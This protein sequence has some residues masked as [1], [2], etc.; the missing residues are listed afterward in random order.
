MSRV[1]LRKHQREL[2]DEIV[3]LLEVP[4][5]GVVPSAGL[6]ATLV[7][8][9][10]TGKTLVGV[11]AA[12]RLVPR[13]RVLVMVPT[14]AL[15][16]QTVEKWREAGDVRE[17]IA[18]CSM[19]GEEVLEE[20]G[21]RCT[22]SAPQLALWGG[23]G[24]VVVFATYA[25]LNLRRDGGGQVV[26]GPL[27]RAM[28]GVYGQ[29]LAPFDLVIVD[30][31]HRT[32]GAWGKAWAAV[33]DNE[34]IPADRRL[35]MTATPRLWALPEQMVAAGLGGGG[36]DV[37]GGDEGLGE[38]GV[39]AAESAA[40]G[41]VEAGEGAEGGCGA[42]RV[43]ASMDDEEL[44]G[45]QVT[46]G[47]LEAVETG[48]LASFEIDVLEI[49]DP[50]PVAE[51]ASLEEARWRRLSALQAALLTHMDATGARSWITFHH[52]TREAMRFARGMPGAAAELY[53]V[54]AARYPAPEWV[55]SEWLCGEHG[56]EWRRAVLGQFAD[57]RDAR[58][59]EQAALFLASCKV[60]GEGVDIV[61]ERGVDGVCFADTRGG[62]VD[63]VQ[64]VG[65]G[66]RQQP[67]EGK[68]A[69][70]VVPVFLQPGESPGDMISSSSYRP[71]V[72][73]L[74]GLRA[75]DERVIEQLVLR[76][77]HT[78][79]GEA[80]DVL[81]EDPQY[82]RE[83]GGERGS[84]EAAGDGGADSGEGGETGVEGAAGAAGEGKGGVGALRFSTPR[85]LAT[86]ARFVRT[87]VLQPD[88]EVWLRGY[89]LLAQWADRWGHARVPAQERVPVGG[90]EEYALGAWVVEQR[91]A[92]REGWLKPWRFERLDAL[93][94]VW[95]VRDAR[96]EEKL[97]VFRRYFEVHA[98]LAAPL[99][100]V[101]ENHPVGQDLANLRK[102]GGLGKKP[103]RAAERRAALEAIDPDWN[104]EWPVAWQRRWAKVRL[105]LVS[106]ASLGD[107]L[108]GVHV[109]GEDVGAWLVE[110]R[111][112]WRSLSEGQRGRLQWLGVGAPNE[113]ATG[114]EGLAGGGERVA[115]PAGASSW[116]RGVAAM[117]QFQA[118]EGGVRVPRA[119]R[120]VILVDHGLGGVVEESVR[121]GVW[122][123]NA[124]ARR[125]KLTPRQRAEAEGL[126]VLA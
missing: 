89:Q 42:D 107:V 10:G 83:Y 1:S 102:P 99:G 18:V 49:Q 60:L 80:E 38:E 55:W 19:G 63:I 11:E 94:V 24:P 67:G 120:E 13:G 7:S 111:V 23:D 122:R 8:A 96:F 117:R 15:L 41:V 68:V 79:R 110:Q 118:R 86:I 45:P 78:G 74:Q 6:R 85:D 92:H 47:L 53:G 12:R 95:D 44:F 126:G 22:T 52:R 61:G 121:L 36:E 20:L 56:G 124:R 39:L 35:Y 69:R 125:E 112:S 123:S 73:V 77:E 113:L 51:E 48:V 17:G 76:R 14:L 28:A 84:S 25:S 119:H 37:Q 40:G 101:F 82:V 106:G 88:S 81:V 30:E 72:A 26:P 4:V 21:V 105:C 29:R 75:H 31:A 33:H 65:R 32:S 103:E 71:L 16:V 93:G 58:G 54:D 97:A 100:A 43:V 109:D 62:V 98:T 27:E 46:F 66:L 3:P 90:G 87:R 64:N 114:W 59:W 34:R 70:I 91:R 57:G 115:V 50:A 104:P 116:E 2:L 5:G 9:T 108:P